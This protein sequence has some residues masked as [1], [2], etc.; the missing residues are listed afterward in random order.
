MT[1]KKNV[2]D[3]IKKAVDEITKKRVE[4]FLN[5]LDVQ[6]NQIGPVKGKDVSAPTIDGWLRRALSQARLEGVSPN[7]AAFEFWKMLEEAG[8]NISHRES[9]Q[10]MPDPDIESKLARAVEKHYSKSK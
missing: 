2:H 6:M 4:A 5:E 1:T 7:R 3:S 8:A 9:C 10:I